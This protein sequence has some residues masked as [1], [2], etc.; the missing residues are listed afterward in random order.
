MIIDFKVYKNGGNQSGET[1]IYE[2]ELKKI[3]FNCLEVK[4]VSL[5]FKKQGIYRKDFR[6]RR[7]GCPPP[8]YFNQVQ[9]SAAI[10]TMSV[11][12]LSEPG[13]GGIF[14]IYMINSHIA[15]VGVR[16]QELQTQL[17]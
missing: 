16:R 11:L 7:C 15:V 2:I 4:C 17:I 9:L 10:P 13:F 3:L 6:F 5:I 12:K 1:Q 14:V 8:N